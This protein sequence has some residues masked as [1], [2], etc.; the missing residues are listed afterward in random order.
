MSHCCP[1]A[2]RRQGL[3]PGFT[4]I[5]LLVVIAIISILAAILFPVFQKVRENARRASCQ[6]NLKQLALAVTQYTQDADEKYPTTH[7]Q[8]SPPSDVLGW[9]AGWGSEVYPY[10]KSTAVYRCPDDPTAQASNLNGRGETDFPVSYALNTAL[11]GA[12]PGGALAGQSASASTVAF[13]EVQGAQ[14]D[15]L[16]VDDDSGN[17]NAPSMSPGA[18]GG[19][20]GTGYLDRRS[21]GFYATGPSTSV[22][23]GNP[24]RSGAVYPRNGPS[25]HT[26]GSNFALADGHVKFLR[27]AAVSPGFPANSPDNDQDVGVSPHGTS[28]GIAAGTGTMGQGP[29]NFVAT[30]SPI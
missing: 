20:D 13:V 9:G 2:P 30:F 8:Y 22:G 10:V 17:P 26:D 23:M 1:T 11:D 16:N 27:P 6:S 19:D 28:V 3:T 7:W 4:L 21:A 14:A 15:L 12:Q 24:P 5:E 25:R 18:D 29:K